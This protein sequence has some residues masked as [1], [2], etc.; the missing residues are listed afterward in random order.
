MIVT[1]GTNTGV[2]EVVGEA[3]KDYMVTKGVM[4]G[5]VLALGIATWGYVDNN[6][7]LINSKVRTEIFN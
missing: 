2:M 7:A 5:P 4:D 1:G 3:M 6:E